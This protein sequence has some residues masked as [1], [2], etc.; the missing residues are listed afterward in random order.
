MKMFIR[1]SIVLVDLIHLKNKVKFWEA[2]ARQ[3]NFVKSKQILLLYE[4]HYD[5]VKCTVKAVMNNNL[6]F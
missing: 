2:R 5:T 1:I 6:S 3:H 4:L